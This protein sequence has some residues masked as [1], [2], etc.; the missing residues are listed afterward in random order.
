M[1]NSDKPASQIAQFRMTPRW[2][3]T[4]TSSRESF[5]YHIWKERQLTIVSRGIDKLPR[6]LATIGE[7]IMEQTG[8]HVTIMAG[9]P[10]P[11]N[12]GMIMTYLLAKRSIAPNLLKLTEEP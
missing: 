9:G 6:T 3:E 1:K 4:F 5:L 8:W 2:P 12:D 7:S 11:D 10:C